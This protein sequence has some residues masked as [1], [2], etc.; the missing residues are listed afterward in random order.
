MIPARRN[1]PGFGRATFGG[2][3]GRPGRGLAAVAGVLAVL[4]VLA[5]CATAP[6]PVEVP[7]EPV[8]WG[9]EGGGS[10]RNARVDVAVPAGVE[11]QRMVR[12]VAEPGYRPEGYAS[13]VVVG[14]VAFVGHEGRSFDAVR[15]ADGGILWR[16]PTRGR[17]YA[18][19]AWTG[20]VFVVG[21]D[22]GRVYAVTPRGEKAW[23]FA[24]TYP[25]V[26][27][28]LTDGERVYVP[29][30][31][32]NV[33]CL[34]AATGRPL[35]QYGRKFPAHRSVFRAHGLALGGGRVYAGFWDGTV[36]ALD[37]EVGRVLWRASLEGAGFRD[38]AAGPVYEGERVYAGSLD[39]P[40]V[41]LHA[42]TGEILWKADLPAAGGIAVGADAVYVGSPGGALVA[43]DRG[44][45]HELWRAGIGDGV[46]T[47]PV[48]ASGSVVVGSS[49]G[50]LA[51]LDA[52]TGTERFRYS[53]G[54]GLHG[55]PAVLPG[56][57]AFLS[58]GSTLHV[59]GWH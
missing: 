18:S 4:L 16:F 51:V 27:G 19:A 24:T 45:G 31:D 7:T 34:E 44:D 21:D 39:G 36:V 8:M 57:I 23:E 3:R 28:V 46:S 37:P 14:G 26:A 2:R 11:L 52:A 50:P 53:P 42:A 32:G 1:G 5:G 43:L 12:L 59:L 55:Q 13:P 17:V 38:V 41:A 22:A 40:V 47:A 10:S 54:P 20:G 49:D 6:R 33:F 15:L 30:A 9:Q 48:L 35:W 25:V 58:D 56:R 29:V